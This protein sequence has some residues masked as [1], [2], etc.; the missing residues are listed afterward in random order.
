LGWI[1]ERV[2]D[3]PC[4]LDADRINGARFSKLWF[5][6]ALKYFDS[7]DKALQVIIYYTSATIHFE[8]FKH[9]NQI[10]IK[11]FVPLILWKFHL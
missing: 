10:F 11:T 2:L 1:W 3:K 7:V 8:D 4:L 9:P 5:I 6:T